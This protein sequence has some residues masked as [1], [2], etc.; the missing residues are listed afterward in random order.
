VTGGELPP[1]SGK[2]ATVFERSAD[3]PSG[4]GRILLLEALRIDRLLLLV[5]IARSKSAVDEAGLPGSSAKPPAFFPAR[6]RTTIGWKRTPFSLPS[7]K[8]LLDQR[9]HRFPFFSASSAWPSAA[10]AEAG[11]TILPGTGLSSRL[12]D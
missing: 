9:H 4:T 11:A 8:P 2:A 6:L 3:R 12:A 5:L 1:D 7:R 10:G